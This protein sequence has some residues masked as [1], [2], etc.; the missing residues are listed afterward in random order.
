MALEVIA[1]GGPRRV[2]AP[3]P[4]PLRTIAMRDR[5][6]IDVALARVRDGDSWRTIDG[7]VTLFI[8]GHLADT[9]AGDRLRVFGQ[10]RSIRPPA[11]PGEYDFAAYSRSAP[12]VVLGRL[13]VS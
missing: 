11:N 6:R 9:Q 13:R 7:Q 4:D 10:L 3:P 1:I 8:G 2:P 12:P 5:T